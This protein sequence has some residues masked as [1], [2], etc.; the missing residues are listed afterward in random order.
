MFI[1]YVILIIFG[2][3]ISMVKLDQV[4]RDINENS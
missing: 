3:G 4:I 1:V 2:L